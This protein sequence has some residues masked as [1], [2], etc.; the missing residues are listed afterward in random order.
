M[1][2]ILTGPVLWLVFAISF[3]GL[4]V[5]VVLYFKGLNQQLDRVAYRPHLSYGLKGAFNSIISW[6]NPFGAQGWRTRPGFTL[7][8]FALHIGLL[9]TPIFLAAHNIMLQE[10]LGFSLPQLP[11]YAADILSWTVVVACL[12]MVLRR[13][14]FPEVRI[15]TS[16]YDILLIVIAVAPFVTG[17]IARYSAGDYEFWLLAHI[18]TGEIWLLSLPFTKLSHCVLFFCSRAQLGMDYGIKR[19]GMKGSSMSW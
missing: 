15:I 6:L 3:G 16:A 4:L 12:A 18:I 8:F 9:V 7:I 5:R 1:Y 10:N 11:A 19:G 17:L 14:A 13:F 2:D